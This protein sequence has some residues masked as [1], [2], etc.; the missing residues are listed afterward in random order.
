MP[1]APTIEEIIEGLLEFCINN[2]APKDKLEAVDQFVALLNDESSTKENYE[3]AAQLYQHILDERIITAPET[4][5]EIQAKAKD[6]MRLAG[7]E[8]L[9]H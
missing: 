1:I 6:C 9:M 2:H 7:Y 4:I 8:I 5:A 3:L